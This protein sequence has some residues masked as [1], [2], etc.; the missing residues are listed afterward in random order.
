MVR[1]KYQLRNR[2]EP[3]QI[4]QEAKSPGAIGTRVVTRGGATEIDRAAIIVIAVAANTKTEQLH[5]KRDAMANVRTNVL[6]SPVLRVDLNSDLRPD[7]SNN[8]RNEASVGPAMTA[9]A[10]RAQ[11]SIGNA[12]RHAT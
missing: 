3:H 2:F 11:A 1:E 5:R 6:Q 9:P 4:M 8:A 7:P 12:M 10:V